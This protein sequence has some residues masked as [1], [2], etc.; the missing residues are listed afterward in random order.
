MTSYFPPYFG[1]KG[2]EVEGFF[3][4][5]AALGINLEA[6]L[7]PKKF[8]GAFPGPGPDAHC[9]RGPVE[10]GGRLRSRR[11]E[12]PAP[13]GQVQRTCF[14]T[15][16]PGNPKDAEE[17]RALLLLVRARSSGD[18]GGRGK[19]F[20]ATPAGRFSQKSQGGKLRVKARAARGTKESLA[21]WSVQRESDGTGR[22]SSGGE[23]RSTAPS[24]SER[25]FP[26]ALRESSGA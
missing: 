16:P 14:A 15:P 10:A 6:G 11:G 8:A 9:A 24:R 26:A 20:P 19:C 22:R 23:I 12:N 21:P 3:G 5:D 4:G 18:R 1:R 13:A 7:S 17:S 25:L 2:M